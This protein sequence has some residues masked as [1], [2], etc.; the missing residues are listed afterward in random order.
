LKDLKKTDWTIT[1]TPSTNSDLLANIR[2]TYEL[3]KT[4]LESGKIKWFPRQNVS[5]CLLT[6]FHRACFY[7]V[8]SWAL[9]D[10]FNWNSGVTL[11][12]RQYCAW[13]HHLIFWSY[14][15]VGVGFFQFSHLPPHSLHAESSHRVIII[16]YWLAT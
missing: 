4:F 16:W 12:P 6:L 8:F 15:R 3:F 7:P 10:C 5:K 2:Q 13:I 9:L 1:P 11:I 14:S